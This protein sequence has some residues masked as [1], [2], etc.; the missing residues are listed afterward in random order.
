MK[1]E[2]LIVFIIFL[3]KNDLL[4]RYK[5]SLYKTSRITIKSFYYNRIADPIQLIESAFSWVF[6][7]VNKK[8]FV[9]WYFYSNLWKRIVN[10]FL[11]FK[12]KNKI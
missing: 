6:E 12:A 10:D 3:K 5:T 1:E 11:T 2:L 7:N 9:D 4:E 8:Q